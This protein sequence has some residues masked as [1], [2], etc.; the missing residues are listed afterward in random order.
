MVKFSPRQTALIASLCLLGPVWAQESKPAPEQ[1]PIR[2]IYVPFEDL[3]VILDNDKHRA[4]LTREEYDELVKLAKA[5]PQSPAPHKIALVAAEYEGQL[6]DGRA[7][8]TGQ[9]QIE[10]LD[11]GLFALPLELGGVGI[12]SALLDDKPAALSRNAQQQPIVLVQGKGLHKLELKLTAPLQTAAAQQTLQVSLPS[13]SATKLKL[14][15][16]GN[17]DVKGG[18]AVFSRTYDMAGN[19]TLLELLPQRGGMSVVMSLNNRLL[20]DQRVVVARGVIV[21]E[22]TQGYERIHATISYRVLHGAVEKLRL[23]VPAGF[24]VTKVDSVLLAKWEEKTENGRQILETTLREATSEQIVLHL[25]ANRSPAAGADWLAGLADWKFPKLEPLDTAGNVAVV[26]L[27]LEDRLK[28]EQI[29]SSG[30]VPVDLAALTGAIPASVLKAEPGAPMVRQVVSYYAPGNEYSL[31][32]R[33]VRPPAGLKVA[34]NSLL[35]I[36][37]SGLTLQGGFALTPEAESLF[38]L[39]FTLPAGWQVTQVTAPDGSPLPVERY[40]IAAGGTRISVRLTK[41]IPINQTQTVNY[42]AIFTPAGWLG[43]WTTQKVEFPKV[44]LEG[45]TSDS[46]AVAAQT[47]DDLIVRPDQLTS[48]T[49]LLD[50]EKATYGLGGITTA[51]AYR[52]ENRDFAASL[53]VERTA[54]SLAAQVY[55][56]LRLERDNLAAHYELFYDV[57]EAR[58]RRVAFSLPIG[59]PAELTIKGLGNTGVK[60]FTSVAEGQRRRWTVQLAERQ[61]GEVK[62]QVEFTQTLSDTAQQNYPLPLVQAEDVEYQSAVVAVEGDA[63]L[64]V[65]VVPTAARPVDI[66]ELAG[67]E[68]PLQ[69][70][71]RVIGTYGYVGTATQIVAT[72]ARREAYTLPP[73]LI[74][75]AELVTKVSA[76]GVA[77]SVARYDLV[78]KATLLEIKL[79]AGSQLWT[80]F[81]DNQPTKPQREGESLLLS[82]AA[83]ERVAVRK[84]QLVYESPSQKLGLSG[85]IDAFAPTLLIRATGTDAEREIPQADLEWKLILP[86]GYTVRRAG[87]SVFTD[88]IPP[89]QLAA[90]KV[91]GALYEL[92]GGVQPWYWAEQTSS[93]A[94]RMSTSNHLQQRGFA[95]HDYSDSYAVPKSEAATAATPAPAAADPFGPAP[96]ADMPVPKAPAGESKPEESKPQEAAPPP[97]MAAPAPA[98]MDDAPAQTRDLQAREKMAQVQGPGSISGFESNL[99]LQVQQSQQVHGQMDKSFWA[100]EGVSSLQID[101]AADAPATTFRSLGEQPQL[102]AVVTDQRRIGAAACGLGLL[103]LLVGVGLTNRP[104]RVKATFV[105]V[106]L[107]ASTVPLLLTTAFDEVGQVFDY[108]FYA[109]CALIA[110]YLIAAVVCAIYHGIKSRLPAD[111]CRPP[112]TQIVALLIAAGLMLVANTAIAQQPADD[113]TPVAVPKDAIIVPY[114]P[115]KPR[116][117]DAKQKILVPYAKYVELWNLAHPDKKIETTPPPVGFAIAGTSYETTLGTADFLSLVG[118]MQIDV[119]GDKPVSVPLHLAGGVLEK[120]TV[121]GQAAKLQLVEPEPNQQPAQQQ[122]KAAGTLP[123][124]MLLLHLSGKGRKSI[125]L[126]VRL[127]LARQGGWRIVHGQLPVGPATALTLTAPTAGTEIRQNGLAD[128]ATFETKAADEKIETALGPGGAV[129]LQWRPKVGEGMVDQALTARSIV[130]FDVRE[131]SL[132]VAWQVRLEFGRAFRDS[133]SL[134][135]PA[136]Y[137]VE[138]VTGDNVRGW[139]VKKEGEGQRIDVTLLKPVQGGETLTLQLARRGRVGQGDLA[140]FDAPLIQVEGAALE[141]GEIAVRRSPRLDLRTLS[142]ASLVRA[143][144]G[145]QTAAVEQLA[146]AA[147]AAVLLVKPFQ[148]F[149]FV[150]P[151]FRLS[152][153]AAEMPQGA[154]AEIKAALQ[155]AE[156]G[157]TLDAAITFRPE[158][159]PL[160]QVRMYLPEGFSLDRLGP[161]DL[162]WA[163]TTENNRKLLTVYLLDGR[164]DQFTLTLFGKIAPPAPAAAQPAAAP[165]ADQPPPRSLPLPVLEVLDVQKQEGEIVLVPDPDTDVRLDAV[166][167]AETAPLTGGPGWMKGEQ[168]PLAKAVLRYR[169]AGYGATITL[170]PRTP[171][172]AARSISNVKITPRSIEETVLIDFQIDQAGI[173]RVSFLVPQHLAKARLKAKLLKQK[174]VET[175][176]GAAGSPPAGMVRIRLEL[177]DYVRGNY[178]VLLEHDRL[179]VAGKQRIDLPVIETGRTDRRLVALENAGRDEVVIGANDAPGLEP[180]NRQQQAWRDLTAVLGENVTQAYAAL[181]NAQQPNLSF[182]TVERQQADRASARIELGT[183]LLVVDAS[184]AYR[185]LVQYRMK[186]AKEQF[187]EFTLPAGARLWTAQVAGEP[188]KPAQAV[189]PKPGVVRIPL[190]KSAEGDG[191]YLVELKYGGKLPAAPGLGAVSFPLIRQTNINVEES[192]VRLLL[193][194]TQHWFNFDG[195]LTLVPSEEDLQKGFQ[196]YLNRRITEA[197]QDLASGDDFTKVRAATNLK[198]SRQ[199]LEFNRRSQAGNNLKQ[200]ELETTNESLLYEAEQRAQSEL[201]QQ[202]RG[203]VT[204]N[205]SRLNYAWGKQDVTRSKNVVSELGSNFDG[206]AQN[207]SGKTKGDDALNPAFLEQNKLRTESEKDG[208]DSGAIAGKPGAQSGEAAEGKGQGRYFRGIA[209]QPNDQSGGGQQGQGQSADGGR[210]APEIAAKKELDEL[211]QKFQQ[212]ADGRETGRRLSGDRAQQLQRYQQNLEQND[213]QAQSQYNY[214]TPNLPA[215]GQPMNGQPGYGVPQAGSGGG[216]FGMQPNLPGS[217]PPRGAGGMPG[218]GGMP[219]GQTAQIP[220]P[221]APVTTNEFHAQ[222]PGRPQAAAEDLSQ[223]AAGLASLDVRLPERGKLYRFTT[224][225]GDLEIVARAVPV[226]VLHR[227]LGLAVV[228]GAILVLWLLGREKSRRVWAAI[229]RSLAFAVVLIVAGLFSVIVGIFPVAG[230]IALVAGIVLLILRRRP[231]PVAVAAA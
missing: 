200:L 99:S 180:I 212:E 45:A 101:I 125:E 67:S 134:T 51:L 47:T 223:V 190:I 55:S 14:T 185:S 100:L 28:P 108:V 152:L 59:T 145:G 74:E 132:R 60:E 187:L 116:E 193:P 15:V 95:T 228:L 34:G 201:A 205:R 69:K 121:D 71:K 23:A 229:F 61:I 144:A 21:D 72:I 117:E 111:C 26:G 183:T 143:D 41:G 115:D 42:Q 206:T 49:P 94:R 10:V 172:I 139:T 195:K 11:D 158:G 173:R 225:R 165:A 65:T 202:Q 150:K 129:D 62:L 164:S 163:I 86:T 214:A 133:F 198:Q 170:T 113:T 231:T 107:L 142:V 92:A 35:V 19:R 36:G 204:D 114:D 224:P 78:T 128:R 199:L 82:L 43:E 154:T 168:Q 184:G 80:V 32:A 126:H 8:I 44:L 96:A 186:S 37:D 157:T 7:L 50:N 219:S 24:E 156:R 31:S 227:L 18:A 56:V 220:M 110:Y 217:G 182:A 17:V 85:T 160:Y 75:R 141:Q 87:G 91:A 68:Y 3:N 63:E 177:Q 171:L 89:R 211:Q 39:A 120:A 169:A 12:R 77:Q 29:T 58:T 64:D 90:I 175:A 189:P 88:E 73:A 210:K 124:R 136:D 13:I 138:S 194:E 27:L 153:A 181:D 30:L 2:E 207:D 218:G 105:I 221:P 146:D 16:P 151:P 109:G 103:V 162:E 188:V 52:F 149:R 122:A 70:L 46:G 167:N 130:A 213:R 159:L 9:L 66:G 178:S 83:Q 174:T 84:L 112:V 97:P 203:E 161:A 226:V 155:L 208:K 216:G 140:E 197:T 191:D 123:P 179:L 147:D 119:F 57:R 176:T 196:A 22:V 135:A 38:Q 192:Q 127:G 230:L 137:L 104:T 93:A 131:D 79:P 148:T 76:A 102:E 209:N 5:K 222:L 81:L 106:V 54:P 215:G 40:P 98:K 53:I 25:T 1:P 48:L 4:F 6:E 33:F 20:Q 166:K 118:K